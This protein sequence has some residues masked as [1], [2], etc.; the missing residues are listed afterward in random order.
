MR[1]YRILR[2]I[3][4]EKEIKDLRLSALLSDKFIIFIH[5]HRKQKYLPVAHVFCHQAMQETTAISNIRRVSMGRRK[6]R[7]FPDLKSD[8]SYTTYFSASCNPMTLTVFS[9]T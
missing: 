1:G 2:I 4:T 6:K 3:P 8:I 7:K 9:I 5:V